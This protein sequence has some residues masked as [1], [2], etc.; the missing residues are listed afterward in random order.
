MSPYFRLK[1]NKIIHY[2]GRL[3]PSSEV[4]EGF[5]SQLT[6]R[7]FGASA[8]ALPHT[9]AVAAFAK[10]MRAPSHFEPKMIDV[11]TQI[12]VQV[13]SLNQIKDFDSLLYMLDIVLLEPP[14]FFVVAPGGPPA[15]VPLALIFS[16]LSNTAAGYDLFRRPAF[17]AAMKELLDSWGAYLRSP[18]STKTLTDSNG[19]WFSPPGLNMLEDLRGEFNSTYVCPNPTQTNRGFRSW[20]EFF[21]REI[22]AD[23]R[24][25]HF[26]HNA[27]IDAG[28]I[29]S[30]CEA[31]VLYVQRNLQIHAQ[32]W[33]KGQ[34][35]SLYDMLD[36]DNA[37]STAFVGG[38]AY[39]AA[40]SPADY[41]RWRSPV[42]GTIAK[43]VVVPGTYCAVLPD[44]GADSPYGAMP[45]SQ[46][47]ITHSATRAL[48][49]IDNPKIGLV[50]FLAVGMVEVS[51]CEL[52]VEAGQK[53]ERG[54][55]LGMF[56][57]GG[58]THV[59]LFGPGANIT[60]RDDIVDRET[61]DVKI[62]SHIKVLS[63]LAQAG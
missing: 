42:A 63:A 50:C 31:S 45:R 16:L 7:A 30:P 27:A 11:F 28:I 56:H 19:G 33:L 25:M 59:L 52:T 62:D 61:G 54:A 10:A 58:S 38:T 46:R 60:F 3:P 34:K 15:G 41:H 22:Q 26:S 12:F 6:D 13:S 55:Q 29:V 40:L 37:F 43:A 49:Y 24:P 23:A 44:D 2:D 51:T 57:Y 48:V 14:G 9:P 4:Y 20:D 35:Y 39:Q 21:T 53:V 32:F 36:R 8:K 5:F 1:H 18:D 17:N 47:W